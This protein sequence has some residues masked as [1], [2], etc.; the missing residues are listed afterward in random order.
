MGWSAR[1]SMA[2]P[3]GMRL[4]GLLVW[5]IGRLRRWED[6]L[7]VREQRADAVSKLVSRPSTARSKI[8]RNERCPCGQV[9]ST[10]TA[11][12]WPAAE[13]SAGHGRGP[14]TD[15]PTS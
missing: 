2:G 4:M 10:S 5:W 12:A 11:T 9:S 1:R 3:A 6:E 7:E 14:A 8:G 15:R 13:R